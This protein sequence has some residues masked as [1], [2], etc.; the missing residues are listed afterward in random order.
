[1]DPTSP[2]DTPPPSRR[3]T[4]RG[5][6]ILLIVGGILG[7]GCWT[8]LTYMVEGLVWGG[9][10]SGAPGRPIPF[11]S[12]VAAVSTGALILA[13]VLL[14]SAANP[15]QGPT[16][17]GVAKTAFWVMALAAAGYVFGFVLCATG[18]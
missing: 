6:G 5:L 18:N 1:M 14:T 11:A 12:L 4:W 2:Q 13:G 15:E 17:K 7:G 8:V 16:A 9:D 3:S 10:H